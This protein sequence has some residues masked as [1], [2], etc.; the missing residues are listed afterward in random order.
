MAFSSTVTAA[1]SY[2]VGPKR[3]RG[4]TFTQTLGSDS[5]GDITTGLS[6][7]DTYGYN[8]TSHMD[9]VLPKVTTSGGTLTLLMEGNGDGTWWVI[10][11]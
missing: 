6:A 3:H 11:L 4:G 5:G 10:G 2:H 7:I 1:Q 9:G 8:L